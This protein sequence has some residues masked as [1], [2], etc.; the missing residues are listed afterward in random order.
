VSPF[1]EAVGRKFFDID[2]PKADYL[3]L[4]N[5]RFIADLMPTHPLYFPL[6]PPAAQA[7]I[8]EP[9]PQSRGALKLLEDEG[10]Q[11]AEMVDIFDA[12]PIVRA[13]VAELRAVKD[14]TRAVVAGIVDTEL[15][16]ESFLI[17]RHASKEG[18]RAC[19]GH[20]GAMADGA[21]RIS[22][23]LADRLE[24]RMGD[25]IRFAPMHGSARRASDS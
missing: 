8:G 7:V 17:A 4:L 9:H 11:S 20:V 25:S 16:H 2:F 21:V 23:A 24:V 13:H 22:A 1:W 19:I 18:F 3:S 6:L 15:A 5:K 12:G 14:S 10:F